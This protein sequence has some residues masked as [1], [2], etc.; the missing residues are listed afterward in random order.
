MAG[1]IGD[2]ARQVLHGRAGQAFEP[3]AAIVRQPLGAVEEFDAV[4]AASWVDGRQAALRAV[5]ALDHAIPSLPCIAA[6]IGL[7]RQVGSE[8]RR[9]EHAVVV[10]HEEHG[11]AGR[12]ILDLWQWC[13]REPLVQP[14]AGDRELRQIASVVAVEVHSARAGQYLPGLRV[15]LVDQGHAD[16]GLHVGDP[17]QAQGPCAQ[18]SDPVALAGREIATR[19]ASS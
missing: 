3:R 14:G 8:R 13:G 4:G 16:A 11:I 7:R 2:L 6:D 17:V 1:R 19:A 5:S 15:E 12:R 10:C 18:L 9:I